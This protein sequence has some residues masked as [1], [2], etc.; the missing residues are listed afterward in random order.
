MKFYMELIFVIFKGATESH[1]SQFL[2]KKCLLEKCIYTYF[3]KTIE[4]E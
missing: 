3:V 1:N 4:E 2:L